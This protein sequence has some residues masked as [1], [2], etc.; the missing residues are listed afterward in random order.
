MEKKIA[1]SY[2]GKKGECFQFFP[3]NILHLNLIALF[4]GH[5]QEMFLRIISLISRKQSECKTAIKRGHRKIKQNIDR[6]RDHPESRQ[7]KLEIWEENKN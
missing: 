1:G 3:A 7:L 6:Y 4:T 5:P 2:S